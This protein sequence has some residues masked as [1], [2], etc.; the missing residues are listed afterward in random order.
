MV[1]L[2]ESVESRLLVI[3]ATIDVLFS[4]QVA[5]DR[6][7]VLVWPPLL[8]TVFTGLSLVKDFAQVDKQ[9]NFVAFEARSQDLRQQAQTV[10]VVG[11]LFLAK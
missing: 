4:A 7:G 1:E 9:L 5:I 10:L 3:V 8:V 2:L 6:R 11:Q